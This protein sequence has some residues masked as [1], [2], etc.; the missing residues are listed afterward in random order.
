MTIT[1]QY[2]TW[3][4]YVGE[5]SVRDGIETALAGLTAGYDMDALEQAYRAAVNAALPDGVTLDGDLIHG[6]YSMRC[7]E[8]TAEITEVIK[9]VDFWA[10]AG[11][12]EL[13]EVPTA[14]EL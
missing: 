5:L 12:H 11:Q 10:L 3:Q 14:F 1:T 9:G 4:N 6:P 2:G 13:P 8:T 7:V